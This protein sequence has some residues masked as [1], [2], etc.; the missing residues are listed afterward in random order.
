M[1]QAGCGEKM[2]KNKCMNPPARFASAEMDSHTSKFAKAQPY[3]CDIEKTES[4]WLATA[5]LKLST[6]AT[7]EHVKCKCLKQY[8]LRPFSVTFC[9]LKWRSWYL[10]DL[11]LNHQPHSLKT[12]SSDIYHLYIFL[13]RIRYSLGLGCILITLTWLLLVCWSRPSHT[14]RRPSAVGCHPSLGR[15]P[16]V[17]KQPTKAA[18]LLGLEYDGSFLD[19]KCEWL[20][21][22]DLYRGTWWYMYCI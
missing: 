22:L 3:K 6:I 14:S 16:W 19:L 9:K 21:I 17:S 11:S 10:P 1:I 18:W 20:I 5:C 13:L 12:P 15:N 7:C 4:C 2:E 8:S